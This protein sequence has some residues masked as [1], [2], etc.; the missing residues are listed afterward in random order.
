MRNANT[1]I[2]NQSLFQ[3][4]HNLLNMV[5]HPLL[6]NNVN[7]GLFHYETLSVILLNFFPHMIWI[8]QSNLKLYQIEYYLQ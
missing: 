6:D 4:S 5:F 1:I 2:L 3:S 8:Y 7:N